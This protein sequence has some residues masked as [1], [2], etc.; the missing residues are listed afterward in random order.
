M[1]LASLITAPIPGRSQAPDLM[2][3]QAGMQEVQEEWDQIKAERMKER[4]VI[5]DQIAQEEMDKAMNGPEH[6][7]YRAAGNDPMAIA[8]METRKRLEPL[9]A[10]W[11]EE[12]AALE[13]EMAVKMQKVMEETMG[14]PMAP[15]AGSP[16]G[17]APVG[18][19]N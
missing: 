13:A 12:D 9:D 16:A 4:A 15:P 1:L 19:A 2:K 6:A 7:A 14:Y 10:Q 3:M 17:I 8:E 18:P 5:S 11:K